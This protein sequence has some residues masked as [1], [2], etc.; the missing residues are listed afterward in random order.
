MIAR[1]FSRFAVFPYTATVAVASNI[2]IRLLF[3]GQ[4]RHLVDHWGL[5]IWT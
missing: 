4:R 2:R 3:E 5:L 1:Q